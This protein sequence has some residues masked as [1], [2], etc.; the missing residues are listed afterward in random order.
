MCAQR[1][2]EESQ[3]ELLEIMD[4][5]PDVV[6]QGSWREALAQW[7]QTDRRV[8][9]LLFRRAGSVAP[10]LRPYVSS[11]RITRR[12]ASVMSPALGHRQPACR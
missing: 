6:T 2:L 10:E 7:D 11:Q 4:A 1:T 8:L 5:A 9:S 12:T 3:R